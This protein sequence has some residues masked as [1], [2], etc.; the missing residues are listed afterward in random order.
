MIDVIKLKVLPDM[1]L[2]VAFSDGTGGIFDAHPMLAESGS[3]L[4]PLRDPVYFARVFIEAGAP[5]WP[6][7]FDM[8]PRWL[9]D[10]LRVAGALHARADAAA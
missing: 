6:N 9:Q 8:S 2:S 5:T 1:Q 4:I 7:G 3:M 10:E